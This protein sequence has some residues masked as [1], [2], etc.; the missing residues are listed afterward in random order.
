MWTREAEVNVQPDGIHRNILREGAAVLEVF[1]AV[2]IL[3]H[4]RQVNVLASVIQ[5]ER[6]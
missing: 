1:I 2:V 4:V 3:M 5:M 6:R